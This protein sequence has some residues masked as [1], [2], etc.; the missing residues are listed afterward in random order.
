MGLPGRAVRGDA[1]E[2]RALR[3]LVRADIL[4]PA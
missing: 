2:R 3:H 4:T 1:D